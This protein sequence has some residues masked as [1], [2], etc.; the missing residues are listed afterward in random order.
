M[1][2]ARGRETIDFVRASFRVSIRQTCRTVPA[3]RATYGSRRPEQA[4]LIR[5]IAR[6]ATGKLPPTGEPTKGIRGPG[7][8]A[9]QIVE[10]EDVV[11][12]NR[13]VAAFARRCSG[14]SCIWINERAQDF[15]EHGL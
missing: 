3:C 5:E 7:T 1:T 15:H 12:G 2:P 10:G 4:P 9:G 11:G 13:E 14:R 6:H 8:Q